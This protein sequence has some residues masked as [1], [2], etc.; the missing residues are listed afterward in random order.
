MHSL[1][2]STIRGPLC[3]ALALAL[4]Y[5]AA[6][7]QRAEGLRVERA[8]P[9]APSVQSAHRPPIGSASLRRGTGARPRV[10]VTGYWPPTNEAARPFSQSPT[11]NPQGWAGSDWRGRGYDIVSFFPEFGN[12]NCTSCGQGMGDFEVDYQDTSADFWRI[13]GQEQPVAILT[14]SRGANDHSW[15]VEMNQFNRTNWIADFTPPT[16]ATPSP[17][18][19][20]FP[21]NYK[22]LSALPVQ[23]IVD[24]VAMSGLNLTPFICFSGSGGGYLSEYIAYHGVWYQHLHR[25]PL[26]PAWCIA[27]GHVH[28]GG[29][30]SWPTA[31]AGLEVT[32]E[33][34]LDHLDAVLACAPAPLPYCGVSPNSVGSGTTLDARG[35]PSL[36]TNSFALV[37]HGGPALASSIL[38]FGSGR[39][40][41][42][43]GD[44]QL[45]IASGLRRASAVSQFDSRGAQ[46]LALD[47]AQPMYA[48]LSV[49]STWAFQLW[50]R[51]STPAG[52]NLSDALE[53][54]FCQ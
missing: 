36:A 28:V 19:A 44:G 24:R 1:A 5:G 2:R 52:V 38:I 10:M 13:V 51:D 15:E 39:A 37:A 23:E 14:L 30:V 49:G 3:G 8:A 25:D 7:A 4:S 29:Q 16:A 46:T 43:L 18:D 48:G 21:A 12:P 54:T 42:P 40:M 22:R 26:D 45:C 20:N 50:H 6:S 31:T 9:G 17:P 32:L 53:V 27:A 41:S 34:L 47:L 33:V 11:Q 35:V